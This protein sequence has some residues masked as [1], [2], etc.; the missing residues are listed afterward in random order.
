M[1]GKGGVSGGVFS[2]LQSAT[3]SLDATVLHTGPLSK[4]SEYFHHW[5]FIAENIKV[6]ITIYNRQL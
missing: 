1:L 2:W 6:Y 5:H 4:G 3:S